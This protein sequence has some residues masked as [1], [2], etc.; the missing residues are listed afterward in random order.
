MHPYLQKMVSYINKLLCSTVSWGV[1][2]SF[3]I[4]YLECLRWAEG[5]KLST[6][7]LRVKFK[8]YF[9]DFLICL[10]VIRKT[11]T[12]W[13]C[14][15]REGN[16]RPLL[17]TALYS[18]KELCCKYQCSTYTVRYGISQHTYNKCMLDTNSYWFPIKIHCNKLL[19]YQIKT[20]CTW[21][22]TIGMYGIKIKSPCSMWFRIYFLRFAVRNR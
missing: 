5:V 12:S 7:L 1:F 18:G 16:T 14:V 13:M 10:I 15:E 8:V 20:I 21:H 4:H 22:Y 9:S 17:W 11:S 19:L 2:L 6:I 3:Y